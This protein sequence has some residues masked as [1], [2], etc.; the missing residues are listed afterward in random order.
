MMNTFELQVPS[1]H[2]NGCVKAITRA[3]AELDAQAQV[4]A[5]LEQHTLQVVT[6]QT[7]AAV[8]QAITQAGHPVE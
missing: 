5:Q 3:L 2:C 4:Q 7:R 1:M 6:V 8:V